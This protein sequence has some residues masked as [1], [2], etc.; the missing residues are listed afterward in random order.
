MPTINNRPDHFSRRLDQLREQHSLTDRSINSIFPE[1]TDGV[2][3]WETRLQDRLEEY[4]RHLRNIEIPN[5]PSDVGHNPVDH[6]SS[7]SDAGPRPVEQSKRPGDRQTPFD[8]WVQ[9]L[10][11]MMLEELG[12]GRYP[13]PQGFIAPVYWVENEVVLRQVLMEA[14]GATHIP[15]NALKDTSV[16]HYPGKGTF[17]N[18]HRYE[19]MLEQGNDNP[20][21]RAH[22]IGEVARERWGWGFLLEY[23]TLG[24]LAGQA[25]IWPALSAQRL[26]IPLKDNA[27]AHLAA[28]LHRSWILL[29]AGWSEWIWQ[30]VEFKAR[31]AVGE[32]V[33][34]IPRPGRMM[35]L[36]EKIINVF[37]LY[38]TP[39]GIHLRLMSLIDLV[40]FLFFEESDVLTI[41]LHRVLLETQKF[42]IE[43]DAKVLETIGY[44]LSQILGGFYFSKLESTVGILATPYA[45][46]IATHV[47]SLDFKSSAKNFVEVIENDPRLSA[48]TRLALLA[49]SDAR[50]KYDPRAL[51][52]AAW[53]R[54]HLDGPREFFNK[55]W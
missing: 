23:T 19:D 49:R 45:V 37:P 15:E 12:F 47:P 31:Q 14:C 25:G 29:E 22:L 41:T 32:G 18:R 50:I 48:D 44:R 20:L 9:A 35:E 17:I 4:R 51:F 39:H 2:K 42:C 26:G 10:E 34:H 1:L 3:M 8:A 7:M 5:L 6:S 13:L 28:A 30:F 43:N 11:E 46:L 27:V 33:L 53:E 52:V 54:F 36:L 16:F 38:I 55:N 21:Q 24:Q 40:K